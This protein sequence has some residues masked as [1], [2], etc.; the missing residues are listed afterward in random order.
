MPSSA[1]TFLDQHT[2]APVIQKRTGILEFTKLQWHQIQ[3]HNQLAKYSPKMIIINSTH[4]SLARPVFFIFCLKQ[5]VSSASLFIVNNIFNRFSNLHKCSTHIAPF[6][7][8]DLAVNIDQMINDRHYNKSSD[9]V[10][11][12]KRPFILVFRSV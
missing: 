3:V 7:A 10:F 4:D 6:R 9:F 11:D 1:L 12:I 2:S 8:I 5:W